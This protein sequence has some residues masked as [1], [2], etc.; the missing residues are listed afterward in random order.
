MESMKL[1][2]SRKTALLFGATGLVGHELLER[3]LAHSAYERVVA[4]TRRKLNRSHKK[5]HNPVIDFRKLERYPD[6][7]RGNDV[8]LAIG[9]TIKQA[10]SKEA[11]REV[12]YTFVT[13]IARLAQRAGA[14]QCLLVSSVGANSESSVFY[15]Q[16]KGETEE[17][18]TGLPYWATHVFRPGVLLGN[19]TE[20]RPAER[21]TGAVTS[22]LRQISP[23]ILGKYNPTRVDVLADR[24]VAAAQ[25]MRPGVH[26]YGARQLLNEA[27]LPR[28]N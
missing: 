9:T 11:F 14:T 24:M 23:G 10:G 16:V 2:A 27:T 5:L 1:I 12:D 7:Y 25:A 26:F 8:Y 18:I 6:I 3:L 19:R 28:P 21:I 22:F 15:S 4:P 13:T 20:S 17:A